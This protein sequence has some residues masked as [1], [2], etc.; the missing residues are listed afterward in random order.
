MEVQEIVKVVSEK[1][2]E[3]QKNRKGISKRNRE[4][5]KEISKRNWNYE[6]MSNRN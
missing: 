3:E 1:A 2:R 5:Y 4:E 6:E